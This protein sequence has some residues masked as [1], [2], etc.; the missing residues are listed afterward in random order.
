MSGVRNG[1]HKEYEFFWTPGVTHEL[2]FPLAISSVQFRN[3]ANYNDWERILDYQSKKPANT[4]SKEEYKY[5]TFK[6]ESNDTG[7]VL[8]VI[9]DHEIYHIDMIDVVEILNFEG[10]FD[11]KAI[12][13]GFCNPRSEFS[14]GRS[15]S[16]GIESNSELDN[17]QLKQ[18]KA[19]L[20]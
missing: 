9:F 7:L 3:E 18:I 4:F 11:F 5:I 13:A 2:D 17:I 8:T 20:F 19:S 12:S 16:I 1:E 15:E 14:F 6:D 10:D